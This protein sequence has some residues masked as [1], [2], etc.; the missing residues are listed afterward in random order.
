MLHTNILFCVVGALTNIQVHIHRTP[1]PE[2]TISGICG[3]HRV[4]FR[5]GNEPATR[6]TAAS[7]PATVLTVQ[8]KLYLTLQKLH[9]DPKQQFVDHT[10]S[11][12]VR[13]SNLLYVT[14]QPLTHPATAPTTQS[15]KIVIR[16]S[17]AD[18]WD[19]YLIK[20]TNYLKP[21]N[22]RAIFVSGPRYTYQN[23]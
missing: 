22:G 18:F 4:L 19:I 10:N 12:S 21:Q 16:S 13:E 17:L 1:S 15:K 5:A 8:L 11:Y 14:R 23:N 6:C 9:P 7:C 3:S 2:I 20:S